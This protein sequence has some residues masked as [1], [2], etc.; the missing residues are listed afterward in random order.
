MSGYG[1][2]RTWR[3]VRLESGMRSTADIIADSSLNVRKLAASP[4]RIAFGVPPKPSQSSKC[5]FRMSP[6]GAKQ[7]LT[8]I[9][10]FE[11]ALK[12]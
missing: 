6:V 3:D 8:P 9:D 11:T 12:R 4:M 5:V 10:S 2:F 7:S 1:T